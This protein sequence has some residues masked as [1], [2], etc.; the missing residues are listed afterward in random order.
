MLIFNFE[1]GE[2]VIVWWVCDKI[3]LLVYLLSKDIYIGNIVEIVFKDDINKVII[4]KRNDIVIILSYENVM[5]I[6]VEK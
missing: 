6:F 4:F 3:E 1:F 2:C 5:N